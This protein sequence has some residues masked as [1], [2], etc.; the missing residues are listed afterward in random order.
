MVEARVVI[1]WRQV[2]F[3]AFCLDVFGFLPTNGFCIKPLK[4]KLSAGEQKATEKR[5][6]GSHQRDQHVA[7]G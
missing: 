3:V 6:P 7:V 5:V 1:L 2:F 4:V